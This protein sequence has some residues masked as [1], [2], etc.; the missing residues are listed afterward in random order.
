VDL[1]KIFNEEN[2][3]VKKDVKTTTSIIY[4]NPEK[5]SL[6][7]SKS[8]TVPSE[9]EWLFG[10]ISKSVSVSV[11]DAKSISLLSDFSSIS[12]S[13]KSKSISQS[14]VSKSTVES[15]VLSAI[16]SS[17][18]SQIPVTSSASS[19][20]EEKNISTKV[21]LLAIQEHQSSRVPGEKYWS[22]VI[23]E[24]RPNKVLIDVKTI[25]VIESVISEPKS[26]PC[27][28]IISKSSAVLS[29][30]S[31]S[32]SSTS[33][34]S[35]SSIGVIQEIAKIFTGDKTSSFSSI[36]TPIK[37]NMSSISKAI[38]SVSSSVF[39]SIATES[40]INIGEIAN[41]FKDKSS[42][43]SSSTESRSNTCSIIPKSVS[44]ELGKM[45]PKETSSVVTKTS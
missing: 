15:S 7:L 4:V 33:S 45:L 9:S 23:L 3:N 36:S 42:T 28:S 34:E 43:S 39:S 18:S 8:S 26:V 29:E 27:T 20:G 24:Q 1:E 13:I 37:D 12:L 31:S 2:K 6:S 25:T 41:I 38:T 19:K 35:V 17:I 30:S 10:G 40:G 5:S 11:S 21:P 22:T 14:S 32:K 44:E 16:S